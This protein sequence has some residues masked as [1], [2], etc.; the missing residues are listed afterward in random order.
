MIRYQ[1]H[2]ARDWARENMHGLAN[3]VIPSYTRDLKALNEQGIRHDIRKVIE[4]GF[5][6]TLLVSEVAI[7]LDEYR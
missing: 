3:V 4:Y 5:W 6:G 1:R 7:T 2:E